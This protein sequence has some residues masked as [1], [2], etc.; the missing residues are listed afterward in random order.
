MSSLVYG[1][2][3][4]LLC[5]CWLG[6]RKDIRPV[7][8]SRPVPGESVYIWSD[9]RE[10]K[11]VKQKLNV[12][13]VVVVVIVVVVVLVVVVVVV[14]VLVLVVV[15]LVSYR[16][17]PRRCNVTRIGSSSSRSSGRHRLTYTVHHKW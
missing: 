11:L 1:F 8:S 10:N 14:V 13:V 3:V 7:K 5:H 9:L 6:D 12:V 2:V 15:V 16:S 4:G 17:R